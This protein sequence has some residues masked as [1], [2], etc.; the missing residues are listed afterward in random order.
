[1]IRILIADD[2]ALIRESVRLLLDLQEDFEIVGEAADGH[3]VLDLIEVLEPDIVLMDI[4]MPIMNG[5]EATKR[6]VDRASKTKVLVLT[7]FDD[8]DLVVSALQAGAVGYFLKDT[9]SDDLAAGIRSAHR[10]NSQ[11]SSG[12]IDKIVDHLN[13]E[14]ESNIEIPEGIQNLTKREKEVF[15]LLGTGADYKEIAEALF[16]TEGTVKNYVNKISEQLNVKGR[17]RLAL[18][19]RELSKGLNSNQEFP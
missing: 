13:I 7:T 10:G 5:V 9:P 19:S 14:R 1:M 4:R 17:T 18:L 15:Y 16:I 2:L 6:I 12:I 11:F 8:D 3:Q